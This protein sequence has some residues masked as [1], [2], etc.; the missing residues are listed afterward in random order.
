MAGRDDLL[1]P[2]RF[3][4]IVNYVTLRQHLDA[5]CLSGWISWFSYLRK[6][7]IQVHRWWVLSATPGQPKEEKKKHPDTRRV[8]IAGYH[9]RPTTVSKETYYSVKRDLLQCQKRPTT[10]SKETYYMIVGYQTCFLLSPEEG[11]QWVYS[12]GLIL[13][14]CKDKYKASSLPWSGLI[15][16]VDWSLM[17]YAWGRTR[18]K[19]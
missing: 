19:F 15:W 7:H 13:C 14:F 8:M 6:V 18:K 10:V 2:S 5:P 3:E 11:T 1:S 4:K 16:E 17:H 12:V 9:T